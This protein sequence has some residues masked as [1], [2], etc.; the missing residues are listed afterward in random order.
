MRRG[1]LIG[2][3]VVVAMAASQRVEAARR[4]PRQWTRGSYVERIV[5]RR[6]NGQV[7]VRDMYNGYSNNWPR[8]AWL[9]YGYPHGG[10]DTG[11]GNLESKR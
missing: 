11:I 5:V 8:P 1:A 9:Y 2:L 6:P 3:M 4:S 7:Q 10:D